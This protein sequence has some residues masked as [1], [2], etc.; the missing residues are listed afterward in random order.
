M[1]M[2]S[3]GTSGNRCTIRDV[4]PPASTA[5]Q[6]VGEVDIN[7]VIAYNVREARELRGWTQE[8]FAVHLEPYLGQRLTQ[9]GV[10]SMERAWDGDRKR[11]FDG[12]ELFVFSLVFDLPMIWFLL[13]PPGDKRLIRGTGRP[14]RELYAHLLGVPHQLDALH[15]KLRRLGIADPGEMDAMFE[16]LSGQP[17]SAAQWSYRERRKAM[18]LALLDQYADD[19]DTA[20]EDLGRIV[21][22]LRQVGMRGFIAE[23]TNDRD[24]SRGRR[25]PADEPVSGD[26]VDEDDTASSDSGQSGETPSGTGQ[27]R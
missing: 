9:A 6:P 3:G 14:V 23:K 11:E 18:L 25:S 22:H 20:V 24:I 15:D 2:G 10:S 17:T 8:D 4:H 1:Y 12:Q 13:P 19:F 26:T 27:K 16:R 5:A 21:D 7:Q